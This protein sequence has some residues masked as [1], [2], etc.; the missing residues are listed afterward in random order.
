MV[1]GLFRALNTRSRSKAGTLFFH[2]QLLEFFV[3]AHY[4]DFSERG[5]K[6]RQWQKYFWS[7]IPGSIEITFIIRIAHVNISIILDIS[8]KSQI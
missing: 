2:Q 3:I 4:T 5:D 1:F 8:L 6:H 7:L